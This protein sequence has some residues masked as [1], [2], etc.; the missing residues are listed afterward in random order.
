M[1]M[2]NELE[3]VLRN[4]SGLIEVLVWNFVKGVDKH[5]KPKKK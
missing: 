1:I 4:R 5:E 2:E 3:A